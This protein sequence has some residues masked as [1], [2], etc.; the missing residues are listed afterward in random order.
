MPTVTDVD[1]NVYNTIDIDG[2]CWMKENLRVTHYADGVGSIDFSWA[3]SSSEGYYK[4][5]FDD[6][7]L[8]NTYGLLYNWQAATR[9]DDGGVNTP[10]M[11]NVQGI[12]PTGWHIPTPSEWQNMMSI[13]R[14]TGQYEYYCNQN[15]MYI[16]KALASTEGWASSSPNAPCSPG[17]DQGS[18]NSTG[19]NALPASN[20]G[21]KA[22]FWTSEAD[23]GN[24]MATY[25][26]LLYSNSSVLSTTDDF[27]KYKSIRCVLDD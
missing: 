22:E 8:V 12:C 10:V 2:F 27:G 18:N 4:Y 19:F 6:Y 5:P 11:H 9:G 14:Y 15:R 17:Y 24:E 23:Q 26:Y 13:V 21:Q 20:S 3:S 25:Y 16:A 1:G 7:S